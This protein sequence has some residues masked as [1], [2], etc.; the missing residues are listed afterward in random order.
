MHVGTANPRW[1]GKRFRH[2]RR[3]SNTHICV[4]DKR[5]ISSRGIDSISMNLKF[6]LHLR[7]AKC[8]IHWGPGDAHMRH[9]TGSSSLQIMACRLYD[10]K[11]SYKPMLIYCKMDPHE[12]NPMKFPSIFGMFIIEM[13]FK[14]SSTVW[15]PFCL[16]I[17]VLKPFKTRSIA[18]S[19]E[20]S[21]AIPHNFVG[22]SN[23]LNM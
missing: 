19:H 21:S 1:P 10:P 13:I 11:P 16:D 17:K 12:Q 23:H 9:W 22:V 3:I 2:S 8:L 6:L 4:S 7:T 15:W 20:T 5:P 18:T 14:M